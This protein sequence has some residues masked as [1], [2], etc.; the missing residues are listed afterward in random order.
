MIASPWLRQTFSQLRGATHWETNRLT[1]GGL[2]LSRGLDL[3]SA[4]ADF[5]RLGKQRVGLQFEVDVFGGNIRGN[6]PDEWSSQHC[7]SK[8]AGG[9][10]A[11]PLRQAPDASGLPHR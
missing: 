7:N 6:I 11:I 2:T 5:S 3:Q 4:T 10:R 9:A 1:L 8:I